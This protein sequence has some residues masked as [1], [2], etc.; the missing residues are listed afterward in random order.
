[1]MSHWAGFSFPHGEEV[2]IEELVH[3]HSAGM[4]MNLGSKGWQRN[5]DLWIGFG[6][7]SR[8]PHLDKG[9]SRRLKWDAILT[10]GQTILGSH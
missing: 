3:V 5:K 8:H 10:L 4:V 1:M 6:M 2:G 9:I 7:W